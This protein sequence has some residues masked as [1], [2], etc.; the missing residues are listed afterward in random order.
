MLIINLDFQRRD[1]EKKCMFNNNI[2][3]PWNKIP[4]LWR[5][6]NESQ[7]A[8]RNNSSSEQASVNVTD[9]I[10]K[11]MDKSEIYLLVL[12]DLS[13]AFNTV[14]Q[15]FLLNKHVQLNDT[16]WFE[17]YWHER[18]YSVKIDKIMSKSKS[19]LYGVPQGS[20]VDIILFNI[21]IYDIPK[22]N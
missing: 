10:Y 11:S 15:Y 8:H 17:S 16:T 7:Y 12:L 3:F 13:K 22:I 21:F 4:S 6:P 2:A 20:T 19:N 18:T 1:W 14:N 5:H 9:L